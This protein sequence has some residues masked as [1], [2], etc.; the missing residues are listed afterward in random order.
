[1]S[2]VIGPVEPRTCPYFGLDYY[3]EKFG[4]WFFGREADRGKIISNLRAAR[5]TLLH[6]ES[7]VGK[8]SLLR[9]GVAWR[10]ER[11]AD[12]SFARRG[13]PRSIPIVFSSWKDEPLGELTAAIRTA[14]RPYMAERPDPP[15]PGDRLDVVIE[16]ASNAVNASLLIMLD[17]FDEYFL[18]QTREAIPGQFG[19][20]FARCI[21]RAD[22]RANFLIAIREDTYAGLGELFKGRIANIYGNYLNIDHLDHASAERAIRGPLEIYNSQPGVAEKV[23]IE[24]ALVQAVLE[25]VRTFDALPALAAA[26]DGGLSRVSTPLLQ[27]VME[28]IWTRELV[29]GSRELRLSTLHALRG[30][31]TIV[32]GHLASALG[33]LSK[34]ESQTALDAFDHLVTPSGGTIAESVPDLALRT[35]HNEAEVGSA[36]AK[37]D[38]ARIVRSIPA[39]PGQDPIRFRRYEIFHSVLAPTINRAILIREEERRRLR[40]RR[41]AAVAVALLIVSVLMGFVLFYLGRLSASPR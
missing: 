26:A 32:D 18:Y 9:A 2:E 30:V 29:A 4:E 40:L 21:N 39:P 22:L 16:A 7:G 20:E 34:R 35:G 33:S 38:Q 10:L 8:S 5:L 41:L 25:Q 6:A 19:D 37:L 11:V 1:M 27:L 12:D 13:T 24:D 3:G 14:I 28:K 31:R 17:Q 36:L 15:L 23:S